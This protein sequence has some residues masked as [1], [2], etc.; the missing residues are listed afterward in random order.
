MYA[1]QIPLWLR[2][3]VSYSS[4][5]LIFYQITRLWY[6]TVSNIWSKTICSV[7][8]NWLCFE[9]GQLRSCH[10]AKLSWIKVDSVD[11]IQTLCNKPWFL[12]LFPPHP[13]IQP[14]PIHQSMTFY[15]VAIASVDSTVSIHANSTKIYFCPVCLVSLL[16]NA[17]L[18]SCSISAV[19]PLNMADMVT[20]LVR[21]LKRRCSTRN[22]SVCFTFL[23]I[24]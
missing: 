4:H 9:W 15:F 16:C 3:D 23:M 12:F 5:P 17:K 6:N 1:I 18:E 14:N 10:L 11:T 2:W 21:Y 22:Q 20:H 24:L 13:E 7:F 8:P 19:S